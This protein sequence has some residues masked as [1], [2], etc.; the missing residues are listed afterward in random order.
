MARNHSTY[1]SVP[2]A[3]GRALRLLAEAS[4]AKSVVEIGTSTGYSGL[5][6]CLALRK[7]GGHLTTFELDHGRAIHAREH[8]DQAGVSGLVTIVEG[9]AH[10]R[11]RDV[12][13][14]VD[15]VFID[16]DKTGYVDYLRQV[17]PLVRPGGL[18]L[19]H[20]LD[21]V[22][23]YLRTVQADPNLETILYREGHG[24]IVTL[25]KR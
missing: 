20:N 4:G 10:E 23:D 7:T 5:W 3:D 2:L 18:I 9:N 8:F 22:P 19:A 1:L 17:L 21:S 15:L 13:G 24:L 14:P 25:K 6:F 11:L 16:A 12:R